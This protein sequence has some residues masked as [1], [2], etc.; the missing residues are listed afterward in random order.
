MN[1]RLQEIGKTILLYVIVLTGVAILLLVTG[2]ALPANNT[3]ADRLLGT[4]AQP[5]VVAPIDA[6]SFY[7]EI[8]AMGD[9]YL[10]HPLIVDFYA[11]TADIGY[12]D[13]S[14]GVQY[15]DMIFIELVL[16]NLC[17]EVYA[18][19]YTTSGWTFVGTEREYCS[20]A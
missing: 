10:N 11:R 16:P 5:T 4:F 20:P 9:D 15:G 2:L 17:Y 3:V 13:L 7:E 19:K 14:A 18:Y 1:E 12:Y 6:P 8:E